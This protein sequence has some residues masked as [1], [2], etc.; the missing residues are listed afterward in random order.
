MSELSSH[1]PLRRLYEWVI[2]WAD[3]PHGAVA[4]FLLAFAE[5]S[6]FPVP[7]DV[8]LIA[9]AIG[10]PTRAFRF[11][12]ICTAG[13]VLGGIGGYYIGLFF[14][15]AIGKKILDFYGIWDKFEFVREMYRRY[16]VWFVGIAGLTPIPYKV[17]T[18]AAGVFGM[19][20]PKFIMVSLVSRGIR[21]YVVSALI[22][23]F[24]EKIK[25]F[26]DKYFNILSIVFIILLILGFVIIKMVF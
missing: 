19:N 26:I 13:S 16:D 24:G 6:F 17:F 2:R 23:K 1:G 3:S 10:A 8:L 20:V 5:S 9:L 18:I 15:D 12:F 25:D 7:P 22:W 21:F 4:L 11:A 14:F